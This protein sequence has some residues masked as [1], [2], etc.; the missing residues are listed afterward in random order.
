MEE[1]VCKLPLKLQPY[2][3]LMRLH[4]PAGWVLLLWPSLWSIILASDGIP[5]PWLIILFTLGSIMMRGAGCIINDLID[6]NIDKKVE[7]TKNRPLASGTLS[8]KQAGYL[9]AILLLLSLGL[10]VTLNELTIYI[11]LASII[12]ITI[13]P[14]MKRIT[15]WAQLFLGITFNIGALMGWAAVQGK[16]SITPLAIYTACIFWTLGYDT[17]YS[18][19]DKESDLGIGLKSTALLF[20]EDTKKW[21]ATFYKNLALLIVVAGMSSRQSAIFYIALS[22]AFYHLYWQIQNVDLNSPQD[23]MHKFKSN[24]FFGLLVFLA[25]FI[26]TSAKW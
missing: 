18:H 8:N 20:G 16:L 26:E 6:K 19:Q 1:L 12:P 25:I 4:S 11:G 2:A 23:C 22:P 13:Y 10:L 3:R 7:R 15:S 17:I 21:L 14:F 5:S 9:L 24:M